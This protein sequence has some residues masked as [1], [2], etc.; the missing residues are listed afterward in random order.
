[1]DSHSIGIIWDAL[2]NSINSISLSANTKFIILWLKY[3]YIDVS[4]HDFSFTQQDIL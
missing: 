3:V 1:M 2:L 4:T